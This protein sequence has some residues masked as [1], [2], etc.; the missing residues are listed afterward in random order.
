MTPDLA[1]L[2]DV[3]EAT[4]PAAARERLGP[5]T[6]REGR[7][8][9]KRVSAATAEGPVGP[10]DLERA[11]AAMQA[12]G[13]VPLFQVR[14]G[15]A[16]LDSALGARG[17]R[18]VDPVDV[19]VAPVTALSG[20]RLPRLSA[21]AVWEPL[22][23]MREI[24]TE[25]GIGPARIAVMERVAVPKTGLFARQDDHPA[26]TGFAAIH[27][28]V[29]MVHALEVRA[30][31]RRAGVGRRMM[32]QAALWAEAQGAAHLAVLCTTANAGANALYAG[33]GFC[34]AGTYHYRQKE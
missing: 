2:F 33:M 21:F 26:G 7:G 23:I 13:Q 18:I 31:H 3:A 15:E 34:R 10:A 12:R 30:R 22:E 25:G 9:G 17:Y 32:V 6:L 14:E 27:A 4:W 16:A 19:L 28:G 29:A 24:W 5:I 11:E 8:G 1:T 20:A